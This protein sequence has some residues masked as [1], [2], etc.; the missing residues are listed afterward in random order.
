MDHAYMIHHILGLLGVTT[1]HLE[2]LSLGVP[3][4]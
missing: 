2:V 3:M 4:S 1:F